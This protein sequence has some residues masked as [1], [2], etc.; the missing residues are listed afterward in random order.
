MNYRRRETAR[1]VRL[2]I[3]QI[4]VPAVVG[5]TGLVALHPELKDKA[6]I[7]VNRIKNKFKK[8]RREGLD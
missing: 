5:I 8:I 4:I 1:E 3:G 2:W 7:Q 6:R